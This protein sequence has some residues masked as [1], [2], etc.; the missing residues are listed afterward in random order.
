M[1]STTKK[2]LAKL[3][4]VLFI[5][6]TTTNIQAQSQ[7]DKDKAI[8]IALEAIKIMDNGEYKKSIGMLEKS[9]KLDPEN[10]N[11]PYE[12]GLAYVYQ[13]DYKNAI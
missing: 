7:E 1:T 6:I 9:M 11:Y 10:Y 8:E 2:I 5:A 12:I 4:T 13:K 3:L